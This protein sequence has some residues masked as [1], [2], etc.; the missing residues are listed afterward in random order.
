MNCLIRHRLELEIDGS[1]FIFTETYQI[2]VYSLY[3]DARQWGK[4]AVN[5]LDAAESDL[6]LAGLPKTVKG[7]EDDETANV[8]QGELKT[9]HQELW[10]YAAIAA[11][12]LLVVEWWF[13]HR[14]LRR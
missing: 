9:A 8:N 10:G 4:F 13:Y 1:T 14:N 7:D 6:T 12:L 11:L 2:G 5:L 3:I